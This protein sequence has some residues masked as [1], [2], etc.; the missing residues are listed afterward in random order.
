MDRISGKRK[1]R[2]KR[3]KSIRKKISGTADRPR[4]SVFKSN[5]HMYVQIINDLAGQ[6]ITSASNLEKDNRG[7]GKSVADAAK[8]GEIIGARLKEKKVKQVV[9]DRNGYPFHGIVKAIADG[10]R[11]AGIEF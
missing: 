11:K 3:K 5:K 8:L 7:L 2:L 10:A 6:T 4:M 1:K 9:F